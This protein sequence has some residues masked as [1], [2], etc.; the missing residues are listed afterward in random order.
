MPWLRPCGAALACGARHGNNY[1]GLILRSGM[2]AAAGTCSAPRRLRRWSCRARSGN[3][4]V[5][6]CRTG[7]PDECRRGP[8][9]DC[10]V[11]AQRTNGRSLAEGYRRFGH[12]GIGQRAVGGGLHFHPVTCIHSGGLGLLRPPV[13]ARKPKVCGWIVE[14][15][16]GAGRSPMGAQASPRAS[17]NQPLGTQAIEKVEERRVCCLIGV[18]AQPATVRHIGHHFDGASEIQV[19]VPG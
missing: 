12:H 1:R 3:H 8:A 4:C 11:S 18:E 15:I 10:T 2:M 9:W 17:R 6:A 14:L 19:R 7:I 13:Q 16:V 5:R